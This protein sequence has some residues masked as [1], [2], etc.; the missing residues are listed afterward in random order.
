MTGFK[1]KIFITP[2]VAAAENIFADVGLVQ[3]ATALQM[4]SELL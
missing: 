3:I 2:L 4:L 1:K